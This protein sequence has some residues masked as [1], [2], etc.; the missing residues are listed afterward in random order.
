M[1]RAAAAGLAASGVSLAI[2]TGDNTGTAQAVGRSVG[3]NLVMADQARAP[4][5]RCAKYSGLSCHRS[6]MP[7]T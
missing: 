3:I 1:A 4:R 7:S 6:F 2:L 5:Y